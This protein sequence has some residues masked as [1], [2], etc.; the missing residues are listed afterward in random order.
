MYDDKEVPLRAPLLY[1]LLGLISGF[2]IAS[3]SAVISPIL[4]AIIGVILA[5]L[6]FYFRGFNYIWSPI[7]L[8]ACVCTSWIY[9]PRS[10]FTKYN[11]Y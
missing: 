5:L 8:C 11:N 1:L 2:V 3:N 10:N 4:L 7:F 9:Y 6:S